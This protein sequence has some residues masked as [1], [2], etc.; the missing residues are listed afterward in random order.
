MIRLQVQDQLYRDP[1]HKAYSTLDFQREIAKKLGSNLE[2]RY[3]IV[4]TSILNID[5][6]ARNTLFNENFVETSFCITQTPQVYIDCKVYEDEGNLVVEWDYL[7]G[8]LPDGLLAMMHGLYVECISLMTEQ[9]FNIYHDQLLPKP[10]LEIVHGLNDTEKRWEFK[11]GLHELVMRRVPHRENVRAIASP[12]KIISY[13]RLSE[14]VC[15]FGDYLCKSGIKRN[16]LVGV[17][18]NKGWEQVVAILGIVSSGAAY[19]PLDTSWPKKRILSILQK[20]NIKNVVLSDKFIGVE[21]FG[22]IGMGI[23]MIDI[24][25]VLIKGA[26]SQSNW[27]SVPCDPRDIAYVIFTSGSTGVPKGVGVSH[28]S[29]VNTILDMNQRSGITEDDRVLGLS[30]L[31]FDLSVY[32]I[33]G[34]LGAGGCLVLPDNELKKEPANWVDLIVEHQITLCN[35]VPALLQMLTDF[36]SMNHNYNLNCLRWVWLSGDRIPLTLP[37]S[38]KKFANSCQFLS[39]GG[40]TEAAIWSIC[41]PITAIQS[42]WKTIP[43]LLG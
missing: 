17:I 5:R 31:H 39:L 14:L 36:L 24:E 2:G 20:C 10:V 30:E 28:R 8:I 1:D 34:I 26:V 40:A 29:A 21:S 25:T 19:V 33:F 6:T 37:D 18:L 22:Q 32:D 4:F 42:E 38:F 9:N 27:R 7:D 43:G 12:T 35:S 11:G 15:I 16:D 23:N 13:G 3:P 41:Y